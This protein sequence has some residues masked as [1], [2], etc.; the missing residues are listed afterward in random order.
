MLHA[1]CLANQINN[2]DCQFWLQQDSSLSLAYTYAET[3]LY[4]M[5]KDHRD[6]DRSGTYD[7]GF[8]PYTLK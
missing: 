3:D 2:N 8:H 4:E 1:L 6:R 7:P 5:V